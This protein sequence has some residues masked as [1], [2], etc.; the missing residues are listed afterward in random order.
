MA[1]LSYLLQKELINHEATKGYL[2]RNTKNPVLIERTR[3]SHKQPGQYSSKKY[4]NSEEK[5]LF[6]YK[7]LQELQDYTYYK[8]QRTRYYDKQDSKKEPGHN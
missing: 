8:T 4:D 1:E 6:H 5:T 7:W 2:T 3:E